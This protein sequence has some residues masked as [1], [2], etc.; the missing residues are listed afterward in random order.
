MEIWK[1]LNRMPHYEVSNQGQVRSSLRKTIRILKPASTKD[2]YQLV[3]L[4]K[5]GKKHTSYIH[6]LVAEVFIPNQH[7]LR[8]YVNH[9]DKDPT[10]NNVANLEWV[11]ASENNL[12][13][14]DPDLYNK[15]Q[16]FEQLFD[17]MSQMTSKQQAQWIESGISILAK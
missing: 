5:D 9:I 4:V 14:R 12:H 13:A 1:T 3:C 7:P 16:S 2:G 11:S 15:Y 10:N 6:R 17:I 8:N